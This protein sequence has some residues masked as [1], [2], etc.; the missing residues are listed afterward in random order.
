MY[1]KVNIYE[2]DPIKRGQDYVR[3]KEKEYESAMYRWVHEDPEGNTDI[4]RAVF[5]LKYPKKI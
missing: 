1:R 2:V 4:N 5:R 3:K